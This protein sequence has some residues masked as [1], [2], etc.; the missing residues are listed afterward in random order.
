MSY[1]PVDVSYRPLKRWST[2]PCVLGY[3]PLG[4]FNDLDV[5]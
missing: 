2:L 1:A 3:V 5:F 4:D